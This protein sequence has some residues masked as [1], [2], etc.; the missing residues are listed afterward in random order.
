MNKVNCKQ[1][2]VGTWVF[3]YILLL[4]VTADELRVPRPHLHKLVLL[5]LCNVFVSMDHAIQI[6][7]TTEFVIALCRKLVC[8]MGYLTNF[9]CILW[10]ILYLIFSIVKG[11]IQVFKNVENQDTM[12]NVF[13]HAMTNVLYNIRPFKTRSRSDSFTPSYSVYPIS[14]VLVDY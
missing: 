13:T 11:S 8:Q 5:M 12:Q 14:K 2:T 9:Y 1:M 4:S 6:T 3:I 10:C 7:N